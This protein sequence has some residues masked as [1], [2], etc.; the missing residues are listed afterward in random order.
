MTAYI[1]SRVSIS[2][3]PAMTGYMADAPASVFAYGGEYLVR[4]GDITAIEGEASCERVVVV[5]FPSKEQALAWYNSEE[6]R[7]LRDIRW[8]SADAHIIL[9]PGEA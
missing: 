2:D 9:V 5:K 4:T 3:Q 7:A 6:Y 1:I 8:K